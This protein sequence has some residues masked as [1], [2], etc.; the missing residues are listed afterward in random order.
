[1]HCS[2]FLILQRE[3]KKARLALY[4]KDN[5]YRKYV[6]STLNLSTDEFLGRSAVITSQPKDN[7]LF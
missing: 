1:M 3:L 7:K 2:F 5:S 4:D 6:I